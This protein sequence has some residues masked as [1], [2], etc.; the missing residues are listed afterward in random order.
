MTY[1]VERSNVN[2]IIN[3]IM[4][5]KCNGNY[6]VFQITSY[7]HSLLDQL[8]LMDLQN[9]ESIF[10][11]YLKSDT[12]YTINDIFYS[13]K[14]EYQYY[15][16]VSI[17]ADPHSSLSSYFK[18]LCFKNPST[19]KCK[20]NPA[21]VSNPKTT[22]TSSVKPKAKSNKSRPKKVSQVKIFSNGTS[23]PDPDN[24]IDPNLC[25]PLSTTLEP[26]HY[27]MLD[28]GAI[29]TLVK[30]KEMLHNLRTISS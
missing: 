8:H 21:V 10:K 13:I 27:M 28:S 6:S 22:N 29:V 4:S 16:S 25:R 1:D 24:P 20:N 15:K 11:H 17:I 3:T 2:T 18:K 23:S 26:E 12:P 19:E 9:H 7:L 30:R 5:L 14:R